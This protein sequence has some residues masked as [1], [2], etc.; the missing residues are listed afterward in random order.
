MRKRLIVIAASVVAVAALAVGGVAWATSGGDE[1]PLSGDAKTKA[2]EA[3]LFRV[4]VACMRTEDGWA[5]PAQVAQ[6]DEL[7]YVVSGEVHVEH[8]GGVEQVEA[9]QAVL[10]RAGE[11]VRYSTPSAAEYVALC[12]P[13]FAVSRVRRDGG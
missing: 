6:F 13:A 12:V 2:V 10:V 1:A 4:G 7:T 9:G 3:A 8:D 11:R 5:E